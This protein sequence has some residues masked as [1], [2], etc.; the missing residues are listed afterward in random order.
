MASTVRVCSI[1]IALDIDLRKTVGLVEGKA[2]LQL[3]KKFTFSHGTGVNQIDLVWT[4]DAAAAVT[5]G[6]PVSIDLAGSLVDPLGTAVVFAKI[7]GIII[8]NDGSAATGILEVGG[9][10]N[11]F[12]S[13]LGATGDTV[14]IG[15]G[16]SHVFLNPSLAAYAVTAGTG[17]LLQLAS[18][19]GTVP[20]RVIIIGRSA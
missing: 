11:A 9:G 12:A 6:T 17:D 16:G 3:T 7:V 20:Y 2:P 1:S 4:S 18:A 10:S 19:S 5:S 8:L 13:W 15:P 14:K